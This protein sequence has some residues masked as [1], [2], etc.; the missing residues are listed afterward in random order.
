MRTK[1]ENAK[2]SKSLKRNV[3]KVR[4]TH[5]DRPSVIKRQ[6]SKIG[7][8]VSSTKIGKGSFMARTT[9]LLKRILRLKH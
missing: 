3:K 1:K 5:V 9:V 6:K 7:K 2:R 4:S 8:T